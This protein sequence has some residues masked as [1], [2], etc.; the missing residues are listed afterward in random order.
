MAESI[1]RQGRSLV[2]FGSTSLA[3]ATGAGTHTITVPVTE[4]GILGRL[5]IGVS[6]A[7]ALITTVDRIELNNDLLMSGDSLPIQL[8]SAGGES[9]SAAVYNPA[10]GMAVAVNDSLLVTVTNSAATTDAITVAFTAA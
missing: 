6:N 7:D 8:F 5:V 9:N 2:A 10:L 1:I 3:A 4:P